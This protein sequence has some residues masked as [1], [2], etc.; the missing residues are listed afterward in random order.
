[1]ALRLAYT[2]SL[3]DILCAGAL[4]ASPEDGLLIGRNSST[5][6]YDY[7]PSTLRLART[8]PS[9][10]SI[11]T[12]ANL[13]EGYLRLQ[14][15]MGKHLSSSAAWAFL[16]ADWV[17]SPPFYPFVTT[18]L[19]MGAVVILLATGPRQSHGLPNGNYLAKLPLP[20]ASG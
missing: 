3:P 6:A 17:D 20:N 1:V 2:S 19:S 15:I 7:W 5:L 11:L 14:V 18:V 10:P 16:S 9:Y 12:Y 13:N 8:D 4:L